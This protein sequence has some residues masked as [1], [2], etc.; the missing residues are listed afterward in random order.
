MLRNALALAKD[1]ERELLAAR[2]VA[3]Q[4]SDSTAA[5]RRAPPRV[6]VEERRGRASARSW[7]GGAAQGAKT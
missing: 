6:P 7:D 4:R 3:V 2:D 5:V 1:R